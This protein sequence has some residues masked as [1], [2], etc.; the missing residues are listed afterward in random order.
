ME[1][2]HTAENT[3]VNAVKVIRTK[4]GIRMKQLQGG[5]WA[6]SAGSN[7]YY[8]S[9]TSET[10]KEAFVKALKRRARDYQFKMDIIH[11]E[12]EALNEV[13]PCDPLG[14]LA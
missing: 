13:D 6:E 4:T 2:K 5:A 8:P 11:R 1:T 3:E 12:L 7:K 9:T 14:Y 10:K